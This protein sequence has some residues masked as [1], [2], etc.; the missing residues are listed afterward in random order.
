MRLEKQLH[1]ADRW[2]ICD[3]IFLKLQSCGLSCQPII[4]NTASVYVQMANR[5]SLGRSTPDLVPDASGS[6]FQGSDG[7]R[8]SAE[9]ANEYHSPVSPEDV[10]PV[11][12]TVL[13]SDVWSQIDLSMA[14][15]PSNMAQIAINTLLNRLK[16]SVAS[17]R[18]RIYVS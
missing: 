17:V 15:F 13:K 3:T 16:Q 5:S 1:N 12:S 6:T 7:Q 10:S 2:Y 11:I 14:D 8:H 4:P 9:G 18:V